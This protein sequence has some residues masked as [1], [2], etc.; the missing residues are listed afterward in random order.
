MIWVIILLE[1]QFL[2]DNP[3]SR[4]P[5]LREFLNIP[6]YIP[7]CCL[8]KHSSG[9]L[10]TNVLLFVPK[11][12]NLD[13]SMYKSSLICP[14]VVCVF[15][16]L[17]NDAGK[18]FDIDTFFTCFFTCRIIFLAVSRQLCFCIKAMNRSS[19]PIVILDS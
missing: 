16:G 18:I 4:F 7:F 17:Q 14:R 8:F 15:C 11:G 3:G 6:F 10:W 5:I 13:S 19:A 1:N 9:Q 12:T 2:I